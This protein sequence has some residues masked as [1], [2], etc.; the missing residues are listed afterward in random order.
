MT[1]W[2][3]ERVEETKDAMLRALQVWRETDSGE[4]REYYLR[5][6]KQ[7][8]DAVAEYLRHAEDES[9]S[10][11]RHEAEVTFHELSAGA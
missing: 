2:L 9:A 3:A 11:L 7:H 4:I 10:E 8:R 1:A 5:A 6:R